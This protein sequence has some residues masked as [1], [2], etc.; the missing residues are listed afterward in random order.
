MQ[1]YDV[2]DKKQRIGR[3]FDGG[4]VVLDNLS[5]ATEVVYS[6]GVGDDVSFD[7]HFSIKYNVPVKMYDHTD[8]V[9]IS[10]SG[11]KGL[12]EGANCEF[13]KI[14]ISPIDS[15]QTKVG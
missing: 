10:Y 8:E 5:K 14:G 15:V 3:D 2:S 6:F 11:D 1:I 4:Y 9:N 12:A 7:S 13:Y